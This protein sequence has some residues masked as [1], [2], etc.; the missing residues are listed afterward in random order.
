M[1]ATKD[2]FE[3]TERGI[4]NHSDRMDP[5]SQ[6]WTQCMLNESNRLLNLGVKNEVF[7]NKFK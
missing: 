3:L 2:E 1:N 6:R 5:P 7:L 4:H